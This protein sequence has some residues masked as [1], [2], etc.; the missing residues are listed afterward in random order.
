MS[1]YKMNYLPDDDERL[2]QMTLE[3]E[4]QYMEEYEEWLDNIRKEERKKEIEEYESTN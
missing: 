4:E 3:E 2:Y 1:D